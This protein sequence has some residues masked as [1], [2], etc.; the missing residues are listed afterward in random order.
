MKITAD[1]NVLVRVI[2]RDDIE[3]A[4]AA[5]DLLEAA[6][7][8]F[9]PLPALC[10]FVW[11]LGGAFGL[12]RERIAASIRGMIS[13]AT[14]IV[15]RVAVEAGLRVLDAGGDFADGTIAAAGASMGADTFVSFDRKAIALVSETGIPARHPSELT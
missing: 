14:V 5:L 11:V 13:R 2:V 6:D 1:T 3:Q 8:V 15:D 9:L 7:T 4:E 10:E 12:P